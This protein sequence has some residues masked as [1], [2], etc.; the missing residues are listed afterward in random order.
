[1]SE[2]QNGF[3]SISSLLDGYTVNARA[4]LAGGIYTNASTDDV[5]SSISALGEILGVPAGN[6]YNING[7]T[8]DDGSNVA[9]AVNQLIYAANIARRV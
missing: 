9:S 5:I 4:Q 1:M 3:G 8:Y 7:I 6:T 2:V